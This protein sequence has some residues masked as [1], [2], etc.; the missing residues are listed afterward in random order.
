MTSASGPPPTWPLGLVVADGVVDDVAERL[1]D[2]GDVAG[3]YRLRRDRH[4]HPSIVF[5]DGGAGWI[6]RR[7]RKRSSTSAGPG[8]PVVRLERGRAEVAATW[9]P[10][11]C[12]RWCAR[13]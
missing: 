3:H 1:L 10:R 7:G 11:S 5:G 8:R 6:V 4:R 2:E 12:T 9:R 13:P